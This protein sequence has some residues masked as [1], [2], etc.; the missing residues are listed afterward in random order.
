MSKTPPKPTAFQ[1][2]HWSPVIREDQRSVSTLSDGA[3]FWDRETATHFGRRVIARGGAVMWIRAVPEASF[4]F[5]SVGEYDSIGH[6]TADQINELK[7][8]GA[9]S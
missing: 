1:V 5:A 8:R 7:Q 2:I 3:I 4:A 9:P 6:M